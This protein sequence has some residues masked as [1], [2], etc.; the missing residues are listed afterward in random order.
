[1][2]KFSRV[3]SSR[4]VY[5]MSN[6]IGRICTNL[7]RNVKRYGYGIDELGNRDVT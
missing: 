7:L 4:Y 2:G 6:T 3:D 5:V 1:M